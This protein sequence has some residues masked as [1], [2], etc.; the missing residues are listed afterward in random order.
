MFTYRGW[1]N[2]TA[3]FISRQHIYQNS[4]YNSQHLRDWWNYEKILEWRNA[5]RKVVGS[6]LRWAGKRMSRERLAKREWKR[7]E[8]GR[9]RRGRPNLCWGDSMKRDLEKAGVNKRFCDVSPT[10]ETIKGRRQ[11]LPWR[12]WQQWRW[13]CVNIYS[14]SACTVHPPATWSNCN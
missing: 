4:F 13:T 11:Y 8:H 1:W 10:L 12:G 9:K 7:E 3:S 14:R 2:T 5:K 6:R